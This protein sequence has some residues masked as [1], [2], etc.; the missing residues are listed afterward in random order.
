MRGRLKGEGEQRLEREEVKR[1]RR[2]EW[3][4]SRWLELECLSDGRGVWSVLCLSDRECF[5]LRGEMILSVL[6]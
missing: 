5:W 1:D 6:V 3:V 4:R 2:G